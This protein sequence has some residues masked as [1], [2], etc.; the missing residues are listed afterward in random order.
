M[1]PVRTGPD[2]GNEQEWWS[3][4]IYEMLGYE[5]Q[6]LEPTLSNFRAL[7]HP[8]DRERVD[9]AGRAHLEARDPYDVEFRLRTRSGTHRWFRGRGQAQWD[10][11]GRPVRM[12]GS[13]QDID[14]QKRAVAEGEAEKAVTLGP[15]PPGAGF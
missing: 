13:L 7:V 4:R 10:A 9:E 11:E 2:V 5:E 14:E 3:P 6:A 1:G 8:D 12:A 15:C